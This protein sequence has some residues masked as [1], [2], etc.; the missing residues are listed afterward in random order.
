MKKLKI[1]V[2]GKTYDV[3]VEILDEGHSSPSRPSAPA[4]VTASSVG[5]APTPAPA[6]S[7]PAAAAASGPGLV[8]CPLAGKVVSV[9]VKAGQ[10]VNAGDQL[11][12]LEAMKMNTYVT[13]PAAGTVAE[14]LV[15]PGDA[16][17][18]GQALVRMS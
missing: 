1:T 7:A 9:E 15:K 4:P 8:P 10:Q 14:V 12:V 3:S 2:E 13:A 17:E 16:A 6:P 5:S 18:E 11:V